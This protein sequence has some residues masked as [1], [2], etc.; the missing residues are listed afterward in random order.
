MYVKP[1]LIYVMENRI[2]NKCGFHTGNDAMKGDSGR[3]WTDEN[4]LSFLMRK[5]SN[6]REIN[7]WYNKKN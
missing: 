5:K 6:D 1:A 3:E 2:I 4:L 7:E